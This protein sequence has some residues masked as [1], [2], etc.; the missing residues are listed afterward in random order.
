MTHSDKSHQVH[1]SP[2]RP[3]SGCPS[4][5]I[6]RSLCNDRS[7]GPLGR[8]RFLDARLDGR[9]GRC[10]RSDPARQPCPARHPNSPTWPAHD[11]DELLATGFF[12]WLCDHGRFGVD[13]GAIVRGFPHVLFAEA[14]S[15]NQQL[16]YLAESTDVFHRHPPVQR[17]SPAL[18][19]F[20]G[21]ERRARLLL[22]VGVK[23]APPS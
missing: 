7:P 2:S 1:A 9:R 22:R 10:A 21:S 16:S 3:P 5:P 4:T 6:T 14:N 8:C 15:T 12:S 13:L 18:L 19:W 23:R 11:R 20:G 17:R